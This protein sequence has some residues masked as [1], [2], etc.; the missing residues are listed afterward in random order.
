MNRSFKALLAAGL[1]AHAAVATAT[2]VIHG[3]PNFGPPVDVSG[4]VFSGSVASGGQ[5]GTY[6]NL[7]NSTGL[8]NI[9]FGLNSTGGPW[10]WSGD[11]DG[12]VTA[13]EQFHWFA[14]TATSI[15]YRGQ[16]S[17][18]T[19]FGSQNVLTRLLITAV[20]GG[21]VV[22]DATTQ[23]LGNDV[24]SL[25][26]WTGGTFQVVREIEVS[27]NNGASW[28]DALPYFNSLNTMGQAA[29][30]NL[31]TGFYWENSPT[32]A[33]PVPGT[34]ALAVVALLGLAMTSRRRSDI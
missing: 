28:L 10:G 6:N 8:A 22:S 14:D 19:A 21:S 25:I 13:A 11:M 29:R 1:L 33:V 9:Y 34:L 30:T 23:A 24:H 27:A 5:T 4:A 2:I 7:G 12:T 16:T 20:S 32:G 15:E 3:G 31:G 18:S 17:I 26:H